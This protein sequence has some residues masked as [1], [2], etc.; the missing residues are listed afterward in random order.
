VNSPTTLKKSDLAKRLQVSV[1]TID[2]R[3]AAGELLAP[4]RFS[5]HPRWSADEV[6]TW[7]AA[8]CPKADVWARLQRRRE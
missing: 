2:R 7:I 8:G 3:R 6:A 4:L 5:G 1:R